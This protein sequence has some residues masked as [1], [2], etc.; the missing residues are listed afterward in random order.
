MEAAYDFNAALNA[1][2]TQDITIPGIG[3]PTGLVIFASRATGVNGAAEAH[4]MLSIGFYD[5]V[6]MRCMQ[7]GGQDAV[8]I[9]EH[10]SGPVDAR[11]ISILTPGSS[12]VSG[13][14]TVA[15]ITDGIRL[16]LSGTTSGYRVHGKFHF[17]SCYVGHV[18]TGAN[19]VPVASPNVGHTPALVY[20]AVNERNINSAD[21]TQQRF[22][23]GVASWDGVTIAQKSI[24]IT[25]IRN[26]SPTQSFMRVYTAT[27]GGQHDNNPTITISS[28]GGAGFNITK[29]GAGTAG[30]FIFL[31]TNCN[32]RK[33][34][35]ID[36][37]SPTATGNQTITFGFQPA[38]VGVALSQAATVNTQIFTNDAGSLSLSGFD[39]VRQASVAMSAEDNVTTTK[40]KNYFDDVAI[41]LPNAS[42]NAITHRATFGSF[43][44]TAAVVNY[45]VTDATTA[46][47]GFA[48]AIEA[49]AATSIQ[50]LIMGP[51]MGKA[52]LKGANL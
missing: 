47:L 22:S 16:T 20:G 18:T 36:Y 41:L 11:V 26:V 23:F 33:A 9:A 1:S 13:S 44:A 30:D 34:K 19:G 46:R 28:F 37:S 10:Y 31:S 45:S 14:A 38:S 42:T 43:N 51:N 12:G 6:R 2:G 48:W 8:T 39:G 35:V 49:A 21:T 40:C 32:G 17:G 29:N 5:G 52:L 15:F 27:I 7:A 25:L 24:G 4:S 50:N 3:T